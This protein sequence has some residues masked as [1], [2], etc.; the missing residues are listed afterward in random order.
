MGLGRAREA[1]TKEPL[2]TLK[3]YKYYEYYEYY[4][5]EPDRRSIH[6]AISYLVRKLMVFLEPMCCRGPGGVLT[7]N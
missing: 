1:H 7:G 4:V 2:I 3:K 5:N 6:L